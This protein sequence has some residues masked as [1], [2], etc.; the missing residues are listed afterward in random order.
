ME[1]YLIIILAAIIMILLS[2]TIPAVR[3]II[4]CRIIGKTGIYF[5][6]DLNSCVGPMCICQE[7]K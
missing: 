5:D 3:C 4:G 1:T 7:I 2:I 6:N